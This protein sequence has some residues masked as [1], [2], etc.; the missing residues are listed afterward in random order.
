[1]SSW[2]ILSNSTEKFM[3]VLEN[4]AHIELLISKEEIEIVLKIT[5]KQ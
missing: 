1:M 4:K 2:F 3:G 5:S